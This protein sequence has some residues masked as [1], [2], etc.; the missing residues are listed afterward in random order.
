VCSSFIQILR[1]NLHRFVDL[2]TEAQKRWRLWNQ[3]WGEE[4]YHEVGMLVAQKET[5]KPGDY[6]Y[7]SYTTLKKL[8]LPVEVCTYPGGKI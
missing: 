3:K 7:D 2:H 5:F 8:G 6:A 1:D 4:L